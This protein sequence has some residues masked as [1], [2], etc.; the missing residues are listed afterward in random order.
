MSKSV[1]YDIAKN[2]S[3]RFKITTKSIL[4]HISRILDVLTH[5]FLKVTQNPYLQGFWVTFFLF[6]L[7]KG[8]DKNTRFQ[9][10]LVDRRETTILVS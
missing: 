4:K 1:L 2:R 5:L 3:F 9:F 7:F 6:P 8:I 10:F